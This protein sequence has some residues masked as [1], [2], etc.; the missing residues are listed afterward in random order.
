[1]KLNLIRH[2]VKKKKYVCE[3]ESSTGQ[4]KVHKW[5]S[6]NKLL[7]KDENYNGLKTGTT[8]SAGA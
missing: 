2:I 6:T 7:G 4:R 3:G 1:M 5:V 8:R